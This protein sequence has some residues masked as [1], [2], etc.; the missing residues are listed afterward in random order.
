MWMYPLCVWVPVG[1]LLLGVGFL[2]ASSSNLCV[3]VCVCVRTE[4]LSSAESGSSPAVQE[5]MTRLGFLLGDAI[6]TSSQTNM[7]EK[8]VSMNP[9]GLNT[10]TPTDMQPDTQ[11][12][13]LLHHVSD[14][15]KIR[16]ISSLETGNGFWIFFSVRLHPISLRYQRS[17]IR[18]IDYTAGAVLPSESHFHSRHTTGGAWF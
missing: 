17:F 3:C 4:L 1:M 9:T 11:T 8:Q 18:E 13:C 14:D 2:C 15:C 5:L 10:Q 7:E 16:M 12:P 6:P